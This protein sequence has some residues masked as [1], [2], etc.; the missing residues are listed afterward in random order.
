MKLLTAMAMTVALMGTAQAATIYAN[1]F[2]SGDTTGIT[3]VTTIETSP[4]GQK[5]LGVLA[6]GGVSTLT[7]GT[8]G[9]TNLSVA[10]DLYTLNTLDGDNSTWGRDV[11][12]FAANA[13]TLLS[14]S[15]SNYTDPAFTQS[16]GGLNAPGGTGSASAGGLGYGFPE[17]Y[18]YHFVFGL[19]D[20][21]SLALAFRGLSS[22]GWG[23]EG[24][25]I[26][27]I[28]VS[29]D[30][31]PVPLPAGLPLLAVGMGALGL[32]RRRKA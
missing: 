17:G 6:G 22:Q 20:A 4:N 24:F 16:Y 32:M 31:A 8:S 9:Y 19:A 21:S 10:F 3:G 18:T 1:D 25:G 5:F 26:D 2:T 29:G 28:Q 27:N 15:F 7:L 11:F 13:A 23:D 30:V 12:E 14:A